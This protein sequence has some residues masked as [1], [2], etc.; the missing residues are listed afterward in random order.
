MHLSA[1]YFSAIFEDRIIVLTGAMVPYEIDAIEA[2][3]NFAMA[4][5]YAEAME[6]EGVYICMQGLVG[7]W[8]SIV[9]NKTLGRFEIA[10]G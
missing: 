3:A 6:T 1:A 5:G 4:L 9:K 8:E 7:P 2:T 10:E